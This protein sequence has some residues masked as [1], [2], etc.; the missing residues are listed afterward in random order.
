MRIVSFDYHDKVSYSD[1]KANKVIF[2]DECAG[3]VLSGNK[4]F[5]PVHVLRWIYQDCDLL[6][7]D[8]ELS[9]LGSDSVT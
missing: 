6:K 3:E 2:A 1:E 8:S 4:A 9:A 7:R 5:V